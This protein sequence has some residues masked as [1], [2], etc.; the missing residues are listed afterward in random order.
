MEGSWYR[1]ALGLLVFIALAVQFGHAQSTPGFTAL[2][3]LQL[4]Q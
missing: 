4:G 2:N 3:F 1:V